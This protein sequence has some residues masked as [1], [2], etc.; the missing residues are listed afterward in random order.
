M[1][2][3]VTF[4]EANLRLDKVLAIFCSEKSRSYL[5]KVIDEGLVKVNGEVAKSSL[6]VKENDLIEITYPEDKT[7]SLKGEDIPLNIIYEDSD[8][9][10]IDK[11]QGL[12]VH[13]AAGHWEGTLV[14]AVLNHCKDLSTING[15]IRPGI[16]HRIDK[17]TSGLICIAKNDEAHHK[18]AEQLKDHT[19]N[20]EYVA[21]VKGVIKENSG[22]IDMPIGRHKGNRLKMAADRD[23]KTAITHFTVLDRFETHTLVGL[24]LVTGRTHQIRVHMSE[25]GFPVEGDPLYYGKHYDAL[26]QG[27]Q[28]LT[29]V[30][31]SLIHPSTGELMTF[32][33]KLP[34]YFDEVMAKLKK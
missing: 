9:L 29:A 15:V 3:T 34:P 16:V 27:G 33:T 2:F 25:I 6:K 24:K 26:Y 18:L 14:N 19:M 11:P 21:L 31:L 20:R 10:I 28:L 4:K 22:T 30:K 12:V 5:S 7:I 32:E 13:P 23:G 17:D 1:E 8:I